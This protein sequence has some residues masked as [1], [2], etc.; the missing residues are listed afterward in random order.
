MSDDLVS[1]RKISASNFAWAKR[2][3]WA[4]WLSQAV[5]FVV[6]ALT[7]FSAF[8]PIWG[9]LIGFLL[10]T[11]AE[12]LR[13]RSD[14]LRSK[15]EMFKRKSEMLDGFD[16]YDFSSDVANEL[17]A[18]TGGTY[19]FKDED[20]L[21]GMEF[22]STGT[23]GPRRALE[24]LHES[25]W[26]SKHLA[27]RAAITATVCLVITL[28]VAI[29]ALIFA[30]AAVQ[31]QLAATSNVPTGSPNVNNSSASQI[32]GTVVCGVLTFLISINLFRY[33]F[34]LFHFSAS[35]S[36]AVRT[37]EEMAKTKEDDIAKTQ[38]LLFE[39]QLARQAAPMIPTVIWKW[40]HGWLNRL[41]PEASKKLRS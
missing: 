30:I 20:L 18:K 33:C 41:W 6:N 34:E 7:A 25:A 10:A 1:L 11:V 2:W 14:T 5:A 23:K 24:H 32:V 16:G 13:W 4:F 22:A 36:E 12:L 38:S 28:G 3:F 19:D 29:F 27:K 15:A 31:G 17:A 39:Y 40:N 37:I 8:P 21:K 35:A 26:F 9:T